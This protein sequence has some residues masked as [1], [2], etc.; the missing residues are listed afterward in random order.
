MRIPNPRLLLCGVVAACWALL[1]GAAPLRAQAAPAQGPNALALHIFQDAVQNAR[2]AHARLAGPAPRVVPGNA[3]YQDGLAKL[4]AGQYAEA[5]VP[6]QTALRANP[7]S[8]LYHGDMAAV[9]I[10]LQ[11]VDDASLELVRA[12][13]IQPQNQWYTVALAAVK[14][15]RQ[16]YPDASLNLDAAVSADSSMVDSAVAEAGVAWAWRGRRTTQAQAWAELATQRWPGMA[17]PWLRLAALYRPQH[18]TVRGMR[19]IQRYVALRP[20]DR[21]GLYLYAVYLYDVER[22]D[23]ATV[24]AAEAAQ[25]S[26]NREN[27]SVILF[28]IGARAFTA[29]QD[30]T[31]AARAHQGEKIDLAITALSRVMPIAS[32][33][34]APRAGLYLGFAQLMKVAALDHDAE[35]NRACPSAQALDTLLTRAGDNLRVGVALDSAR[36]SSILNSTIPQYR[37]RARALVSQVCG[38]RR[39]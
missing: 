12:R 13:Q 9:Q 5:A 4:Q 15:L 24:L 3:P 31:A 8:A 25:D 18:D 7:N 17:E 6:M 22:T 19:A 36:V 38:G 21:S 11:S 28:N 29:S 37:D 20:S 10:G 39:P 1:G 34:L 16:Q 33:E 14:A 2:T 27:A 26:T 32:P 30:T 23:S 35:S